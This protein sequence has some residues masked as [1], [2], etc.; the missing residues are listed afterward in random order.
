VGALDRY[1]EARDLPGVAGTSRLSPHL[2]F[3]TVGIRRRLAEARAGWKE[4]DAEGR[5]S[6]DV[7]VGELAWREF[8]A[9][10]LAAFPRAKALAAFATIRAGR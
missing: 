2:R 5:R 8:Y 10:I 7:F 1:A 4:A 3:G 6:I 9:S